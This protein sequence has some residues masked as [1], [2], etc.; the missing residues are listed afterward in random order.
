ML[1]VTILIDERPDGVHLSYDRM[2]SFLK[3]YGTYSA[4]ANLIGLAKILY[5]HQVRLLELIL[6]VHN[7]LAIR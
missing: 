7:R 6:D 4:L 1:P 2:A 5:Q 3:P